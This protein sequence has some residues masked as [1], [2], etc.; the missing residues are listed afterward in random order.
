M[1][2]KISF[3]LSVLL[4]ALTLP[5]GASAQSKSYGKTISSEM[6]HSRAN[7]RHYLRKASSLPQMAAT[8]LRRSPIA[9]PAAT[10][11]RV[12]VAGY[13]PQSN[14]RQN[15][16]YSFD[17]SAN[18]QLTLL[19]H[20]DDYRM[21][22][23]GGGTYYDGR[24][25]YIEW[26]Y[27]AFG[28]D[29]YAHYG[30]VDT[31]TW[32]ELYRSAMDYN[33]I[34]EHSI[35]MDLTYSPKDNVIY[36][37]FEDYNG[38]TDAYT[39]YFGYL[40]EYG[41]RVGI[42]Q[43]DRR[44][45]AIAADSTG[46]VYG[47][48]D[49]GW[50]V[51]FD[52][53]T[54]NSTRIGSTG[55]VPFYL[56]SA[57]F[58]FR[59]DTMY[60]VASG[61]TINTALYSVN[62]TNG[63]VSKLCEIPNN[64]QMLGLYIVDHAYADA[65]PYKPEN[66]AADFVRGSLSG[67][68]SFKMPA[69]AYDGSNLAGT[70]SYTVNIDGGTAAEGTAMPGADVAA[71]VSVSKAGS[72]EISVFA[73]NEAG[74]GPAVKTTLWIGDDLPTAPRN[75][76]AANDGSKVTVSW[77]APS[78]TAHGGFL[79][80]SALRYTVTR[81]PDRKTIAT[82]LAATT[83]TDF[84]LGVPIKTYW[85][86]V[87]ACYGTQAGGAATS[88]NL[89]F[90]THYDVPYFEDFSTQGA[91]DMFTKIDVND[92]GKEWLW[93]SDNKEAGCMANQR[94][95]IS[96]DWLITAAIYLS[97]SKSYVLNF[98]ARSTTNTM[99]EE[100]EIAIGT[101]PTE[102]GMSRILMPRTEV[103]TSVYRNFELEF[104][105]PSDGL[106][107]IGW[108]DIS[109]KYRNWLYIDNISITEGAALYAPGDVSDLT[110]TAGAQGALSATIS[111]KAPLKRADGA[112]LTE[113]TAIK[114][115]NGIDL[116]H[117]FESPAPGAEL[118][119]TDTN[120][121]QG[122]NDYMVLCSNSQ[123]VS[124][125][126]YASVWV[127]VDVP[128]PVTGVK[129]VETNGT[130]TLSWNPVTE[131][132]N[133]GYINPNRIVYYVARSYDADTFVNGIYATTITDTPNSADHR[134]MAYLIAAVSEG[135]A[136]DWAMS[137]VVMVGTPHQLPYAESFA[138][139]ALQGAPWAVFTSVGLG[140]WE[141]KQGG[142]NPFTMGVQDEDGGMIGFVPNADGDTGILYSGKFDISNATNPAMSFWYYNNPGDNGKIEL[143]VSKAGAPFATAIS[144]DFAT[145]GGE[146]GWVKAELPLADYKDAA[147]IKFAFV[148]TAAGGK[149]L[150]ID[151][152]RVY[153]NIA[154]DLAIDAIDVPQRLTFGKHALINVTVKNLGQSAADA[155]TV[156]LYRNGAQSGS[157][158]GEAGLAPDASRTFT[159]E[160]LP[161]L[162]FGTEASYYAMV[163]Y[164]DDMNN[165]NN[166]SKTVVV[167]VK[168]PVFPAVSDLTVNV[169]GSTAHLSWSE[170]VA[171]TGNL[172][173]IT[174]SF[175]DYTPFAGTFGDWLTYD[176]DGFETVGIQYASYSGMYDPK[177]WIVFD[178]I[179]AGLSVAY[180]DGTPNAFA[181]ASGSRYLAAFCSVDYDLSEDMPNDDWLISP[182]LSGYAQTIT[183]DVKRLGMNY[184]ESLEVLVSTTGDNISDF[185][186][187]FSAS[188][189]IAWDEW[190]TLSVPL[191]EGAK[192]FA[193]RCNSYGGFALFVD[194]LTFVPA[195][196]RPVELELKGYN[197]YVDDTRVNAEPLAA[198]AYSHAFTAASH[199]FHVT[200]V[201]DK[202][203]SAASNR[204]TAS[205]AGLDAVSTGFSVATARG[206][207]TI[208]GAMAPVAI[209]SADGRTV[210]AA[211]PAD[212]ITARVAPGVYI[213]TVGTAAT[214]VIV[215]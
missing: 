33:P 68:V 1:Y 43:L 51:A 164:A 175:E 18:P 64:D 79:N 138:G 60:W 137:D 4:L 113:L 11:Q 75:I 3:A 183:F 54:G 7:A 131:G 59:T 103:K 44:Y 119:F 67:T 12:T 85:Y 190:H 124:R 178:P 53:R 56:Q 104:S 125:G 63:A 24:Y 57:C 45:W 47:I 200:A 174:D 207:I 165:G 84:N 192:Y 163:E 202:G 35:A 30:I 10:N 208:S 187:V 154:H 117:T 8:T 58:D 211:E 195:T 188:D 201:Y 148:A 160:E 71:Q 102:Q 37:V 186:A 182:E 121:A 91:W 140:E 181:P 156:K 214:K 112:A 166:T 49:E 115:Y 111:F 109:P 20:D 107:Y 171:D 70:L 193:L 205:P 88:N 168:Q 114:V 189:I 65:A 34:D 105:V 159:F 184:P 167:R 203:E 147:F 36:G 95:D 94:S 139:C 199:T 52:R 133:G 141:F 97:S 66:L 28:D 198:A 123:G 41:E 134:A 209:C 96:D 151:N 215:K 158:T 127:G 69:V 32:T 161:S 22:V 78:G 142:F 172:E 46:G 130:F 212:L 77:D 72:Y 152:I 21:S 50:L 2:K 42:K 16:I 61:R 106:Y 191:P 86:E 180:E 62:L 146:K 93:Y 170:P 150:Y 129:V 194:N 206:I 55:I 210:F 26:H 25:Y 153:D 92:D 118:S 185:T 31:D 40:N 87:S 197:V 9:T 110:V 23:D 179:A 213:V 157:Y 204:L 48:D 99:A 90:G 6:E 177:A 155:Y 169:D 196:E 136:S 162:D 101:S 19:F 132:V 27:S 108:H 176:A 173:A 128:M 13:I 143:Q 39:Y 120:A 82:D 81:F 17:I 80:E 116:V 73:S 145:L 83:A 74:D 76:S 122:V 14:V 144:L 29:I 149:E 15:G 100:F 126:A 89:I 135:G 38:I 98:D 5:V